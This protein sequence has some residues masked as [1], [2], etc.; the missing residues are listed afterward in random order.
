MNAYAILVVNSTWRYLL[1]EA[2][3]RRAQGRE[4]RPAP[5]DRFRCVLGQGDH[6]RRPPTTASPILPSLNEYPYRAEASSP[7]LRPPSQTRTA[8]GS[9]SGGLRVS[10]AVERARVR[11]GSAG[12]SMS[13][14]VAA[15]R[16]VASPGGVRDDLRAQ[17][18]GGRRAAAAPRRRA[19]RS[20]RQLSPHRRRA[21][22]SGDGS[23]LASSRARIDGIGAEGREQLPEHSRHEGRH[24]ARHDEHAIDVGAERGEPR[25]EARERAFEGRGVVA[26]RT[27]SGTRGSCPGAATTTMSSA[28]ACDGGDGVVEQRAAVDRLGELVAPEAGRP[29]AREDDRADP[30]GHRRS[31]RRPRARA[32]SARAHGR[33]ASAAGSLAGRGPRGSPS[34]TCGSCRSRRGSAAGVS[35]SRAASARARAARSR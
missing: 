34:R 16:V 23:P 12:V 5:A 28:T 3:A 7:R 19:R 4:A 21:I 10:A 18:A 6:R 31:C 20:R 35:G 27:P 8:P 13:R 30:L 15:G 1:E 2:A 14:S 9:S 25:R 33:R 29:P 11:P 17:D 32:P 24:V 22:G 26:T